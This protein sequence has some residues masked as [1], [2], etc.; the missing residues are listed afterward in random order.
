MFMRRRDCDGLRGTVDTA[1]LL[2]LRNGDG[3]KRMRTAVSFVHI[4][5]AWH[6]HCNMLHHG[7]TICS[8][9]LDLTGLPHKVERKQSLCSWNCYCETKAV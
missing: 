4:A 2:R 5:L 3:E 7:S 8:S 9:S 1:L 6:L